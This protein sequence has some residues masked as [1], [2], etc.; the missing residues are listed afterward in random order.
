MRAVVQRVKNAGVSS[1][2]TQCGAIEQGLVVFL[3][4][5]HTGQAQFIRE[6]YRR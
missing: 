2:G 4:V 3:G 1:E 5:T 6:R